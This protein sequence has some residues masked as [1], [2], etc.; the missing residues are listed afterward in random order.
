[1]SR[2]KVVIF[3]RGKCR[4]RLVFFFGPD[5]LEIVDDFVY[6][7]VKFNYNGSF[8]KAISKQVSQV[9]KALFAMLTKAKKLRLSIDVQCELYD[10]VVFPVVWQ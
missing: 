7:G 1:M 5:E 4:R 10:Q 8:Q 2:T 3:A 9:R 6:L